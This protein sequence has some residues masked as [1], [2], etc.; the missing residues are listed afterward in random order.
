MILESGHSSQYLTDYKDGKIKKGLGLGIE[1]DEYLRYKDAQMNIILGHD[2]VGKSYWFEWYQLALSSQ[3]D[4]IWCV[5]MGE[6]SSGKVMRD[7]IQMYSG[8]QF[9][10]LTYKEIRR[11]EI[12]IEH[13]FKFIDN[14]KLYTPNQILDIF[15]KVDVNGCFIDPYTGLDRPMTHEANYEFLNKT[16]QFCNQTNKTIYI[17]THPTSESGRNGMLYAKGHQWEGHLRPPMKAHIEGGK[18]FLNRCDDMIIIHR[19]TKHETLR[20]Q[21]LIEVEKV[22]DTDTGGKQTNIDNPLMFSYNYGLG[23]LNQGI[24]AIKRNT[25]ISHSLEVTPINQ[26]M[27]NFE[28]ESTQ[29]NIYVKPN[30]CPF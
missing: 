23:F 30:D 13:W 1:L 16:R 5:W 24:D 29:R 18:P 28:N 21:T 25:G 7:L 3:H 19:L 12:K 4:L 2:N 26:N 10:D 22:K 6:N 9:S 8:K 11:Y 14:S 27:S 20:T 15:D 17:S